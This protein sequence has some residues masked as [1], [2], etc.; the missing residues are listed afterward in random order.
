MTVSRKRILVRQ[1]KEW[2]EILVGFET[3]NRYELFDESGSK[4]G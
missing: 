1:A 2:G 4:S 3:R